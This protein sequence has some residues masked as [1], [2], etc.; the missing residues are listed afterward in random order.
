MAISDKEFINNIYP[1]KCGYNL[2]VLRKTE[3]K[4][5]GRNPLFECIFIE[6]NEKILCRKDHV[7]RGTIQNKSLTEK[8][9][10]EFIGKKWK[11]NDGYIVIPTNKSNK[12]ISNVYAYEGYI[13]GY[14]NK[15]KILFLKSY[16]INGTISNPFLPW[17][18]AEEFNRYLDKYTYKPTISEL[19]KDLNLSLSMI[20]QIIYKYEVFS[21]IQYNSNESNKEKE[22]KIF[23]E[24]ECKEE[25]IKW[26]LKDSKE[27]DIYIPSLQIGFEFNGNYW[28]SE[29]FRDKNYHINKKN[30]A[31]KEGINLIHIWE[32]EWNDETSNIKIF[33]KDI[34]NKNKQ[35]I[36][37]RK[38]IIKELNSSIYKE[39]C[40]KNHIQKSLGA[41]VKL[42]L[43]YR[44]ELVQIMS[45]GVPRF[46]EKY[47][48]EIIRECS[49]LGYIVVGGKEKLW[50][51]FV[52][53]YY[54]KNCISYCDFSKFTGESYLK[55]GFKEEKINLDFV[56]WEQGTNLIFW[57]NPYKNKELSNKCLKIWGS[58]QKTFVWNQMN[59]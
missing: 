41:K 26:V 6:N 51:H 52:K 47:E 24:N 13:E 3:L 54:P 57:R 22:L 2:K 43:F 49:K 27:I 4:Q 12:Q 17:K 53:K 10:N 44:N 39:F 18:S 21:K 14:E 19:S 9:E 36:F 8:H 7:L 5:S 1:Q 42:G 23:I 28:H 32:Y 16:A 40:D 30:Q 35:K 59:I 11:Q 31:L 29:L 25:S 50:K 34:L 56:W 46:T 20:G 45:F 15:G 48:Y 58:G 38:C 55:L 37:A 33:I